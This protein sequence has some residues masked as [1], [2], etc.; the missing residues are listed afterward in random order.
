MIDLSYFKNVDLVSED[1]YY[2]AYGIPIE[3]VNKRG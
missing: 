1:G 2:W 3:L